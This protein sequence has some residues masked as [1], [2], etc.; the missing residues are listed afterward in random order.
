MDQEQA[1]IQEDLRGLVAGDVRCDDLFLQLYASDASVYEIRPLGVVRPRHTDDVVACVQYAA[2]HEIPIHARG[3]G[4]GLAGESLGRGLVLDFSRYMRRIT[5]IDDDTVRVQPG[6]VLA[7]LN[8]QLEPLGRLFGPDPAMSSVTTM[9]SVIA[10][11]AAGSHWLRYGS[12]R[13]H[14]ESLKVVM[15]D[16]QVL[17][18]GN[19]PVEEHRPQDGNWRKRDLVWQ[20]AQTISE[21]ADLIEQHRPKSRVNRCGYQLAGVLSGGKNESLNDSQMDGRRLDVAKLLAG[22]EG[23][24]AL[25]TEA[26]LSTQRLP[27]HVGVCLLFFES[28]EKAAQA[29]G[30]I[31][32]LSPSACDLIDRRHLGLAREADVRYDLLL[33]STAEAMLLVECDSVTCNGDEAAD[34]RDAIVQIIDRVQ[35]KTSLAFG[36][37]L[38]S[39]SEQRELF[40]QLA[41]NVVP[42]LYRLKG[43][44]RP[45]P[46]VEDMAVPPELLPSFLVNMQNVLKRHQVTASL[47]GHVGHGQLHLRPFLNLAD[48]E[49]VLK[50]DRLAG[51]LADEVI[52]VGG[53]ISGEHG[54][55]LSRTPLVRRQY[56]PLYDVFV[57]V[58]E[59]FDPHHIFNPGKIVDGESQ[60]ISG[61]LRPITATLGAP[62]ND[63]DEVISSAEHELVDLQLDW[64]VEEMARVASECNGCG[65]CRSEL[66]ELRMCPIFRYSPSEEASP[67]AKANLMRAVLT[68][69]LDPAVV[70]SD[71]FKRVADLCVNCHQCRLEC[72]AKVDIPK[73]MIEAKA[74][75]VRTNGLRPSD[76]TIARLDRLLLLASFMRPLV[77]WSIAN[78]QA[79]WV[80]EKLTGIAQGRKLP[81]LSRQNFLRRAARQRLTR[82]VKRSGHKV[83]YFVDSYA[84]YFDPQLAE[85]L[86]A[87]LQHNNIAV[88]VP[89]NQTYSGMSLISIGA[90]DRAREVAEKNVALLADA[91][92]Q[93]Y[94]I[95]A[96]EPSAALC[97]QHEYVNLLGDDDARLVADNSSEACTYLWKLHQSGWLQLDLN[98]VNV[99]LGYHRPCHLKALEVGSPG[100]NLLQL[101][102]GLKVIRTEKGCSGMAGTFGLKRENYR[103]SLRAG[104]G[105]ISSLR[106]PALQAGTTE[107]SA[108]KMQMEQGTTK[109]TI[110]PLKL[111]ALSYGLMPEVSELLTARGQDLVVT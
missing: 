30:E 74:A 110:H 13:G 25:I 67:R 105:L 73:L 59:I 24:L 43:S 70:A 101:I 33:P 93:G 31:L 26:T 89:P 92:R 34:V 58:K 82:P 15:S 77:N 17:R 69:R 88:Y 48:P 79:R 56:G 57:R 75:Y 47:F 37:A 18:L 100:E 51:D 94:H 4:T 5:S 54:D 86:V 19:E 44:S 53:T 111:L 10:I 87:L 21:N 55:G 78:R 11:D 95:I 14:V 3:A 23:T 90:L 96:T 46:F 81:R 65:A 104:W 91:V 80:I 35:N 49:D 29:V 72:P 42:T 103:S 84:N 109:P 62:R 61:D 66:P 63:T 52:R 108:C 85:A 39:D 97:L 40:W 99:T 106:N 8:R 71:E 20:L 27:K 38:A 83:L 32:P 2:E 68:G 6:V 60:S 98:P 41:H 16:G 36:S 50:M 64:S 28:L 1:R 9:G 102:P 12:A 7:Q 22:S 45:L 107:C 76:W